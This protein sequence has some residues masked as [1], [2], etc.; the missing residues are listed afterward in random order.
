MSVRPVELV[1]GVVNSDPIGPFNLGGD[2]R[3]FVGAIHPDTANE[4][5]VAPVSPVDKSEKE[6]SIMSV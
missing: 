3:R 4:G 5:F 6:R 2:D 1:I